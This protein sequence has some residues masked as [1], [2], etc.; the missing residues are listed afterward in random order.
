MNSKKLLLAPLALLGIQAVHAHCPLCTGAAIGG[1]ALARI[2][3]VDDSIVGIFIG[4]FIVSTA[5]WFSK[6]LQKRKLKFPLQD[7][8]FVAASF[9]M[10]VVPLY[11]ANVITSFDM[12]RSMPAHHAIFGLG[13]FGIDKLLF[14]IIIGTIGVWLA[15]LLSDGIKEARGKSLWP[16]Q[17]ISFVLIASIVMSIIVWGLTKWI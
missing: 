14:G 17:G 3:G 9:L 2:F 7:E 12:V 1:I 13:V 16:F 5:L 15:L 11:A 8:L 4:A 6:I 10:M